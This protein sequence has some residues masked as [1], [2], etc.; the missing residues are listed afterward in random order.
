MKITIHSQKSDIVTLSNSNII[1]VTKNKLMRLVHPGEYLVRGSDG[2]LWLAKD[3]DNHRHGSVS[4]ELIR[5]GTNLDL[6]VFQ[7]LGALDDKNI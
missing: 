7:V 3:E 2:N 4:T 5:L 1:E 6:A